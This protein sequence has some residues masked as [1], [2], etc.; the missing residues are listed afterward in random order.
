M[1]RQTILRVVLVVVGAVLTLASELHAV[2]ARTLKLTR[3]MVVQG[4]YLRAAV[5]DFQWERQGTHVTVTFSRQGHAVATV[6]GEISTFIRTVLTDTFYFSKHPDGCFYIR[7]L[8][9]ANT[10]KGIVFREVRS[11]PDAAINSPAAKTMLQEGWPNF[12]QRQI[13]SP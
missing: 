11:H 12:D 2:E 8:T 3:P 9:F 6:Q 7:A 5:Y 1:N 10:N 13:G 4:I